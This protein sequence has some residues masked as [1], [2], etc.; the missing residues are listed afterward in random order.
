MSDTQ[1]FEQAMGEL[2]A[3]LGRQG[4]N[5]RVDFHFLPNA[6]Q[7]WVL[8]RAQELKLADRGQQ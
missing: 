2:I 4:L 3:D 7:G 1:Y 6:L 8:R 5:D